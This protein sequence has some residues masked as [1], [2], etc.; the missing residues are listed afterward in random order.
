[1][2]NRRSFNLLIRPVRYGEPK[3]TRSTREPEEL[4]QE[5]AAFRLLAQIATS[6][7]ITDY[8]DDPG[9]AR[10]YLP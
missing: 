2:N 3:Q 7:D 4:A 6:R 8:A 5:V 9:L 10:S 1:M